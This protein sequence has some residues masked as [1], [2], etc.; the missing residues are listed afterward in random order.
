MQILFYV[1]LA[2][3]SLLAFMVGGSGFILGFVL[4]PD[5]RLGLVVI[6]G[7]LI[8]M[9]HPAFLYWLFKK[10]DVITAIATTTF[11]VLASTLLAFFL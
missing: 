4:E 10:M 5:D 2:L 8:Y 9:L 7:G 6:T 1:L 11:S 3:S